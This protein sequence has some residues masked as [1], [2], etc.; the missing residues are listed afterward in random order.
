ME[1]KKIKLNTAPLK[2]IGDQVESGSNPRNIFSASV[3]MCL[4][5]YKNYGEESLTMLVLAHRIEYYMSEE[6]SSQAQDNGFFSPR[7]LL[8]GLDFNHWFFCN[9]RK[10]HD[11]FSA[12]TKGTINGNSSAM[13]LDNA[14]HYG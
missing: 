14:V 13:D 8:C 11:E 4:I 7:N 10:K 5:Y 6:C 1:I 12:F 9:Q 2:H 3:K